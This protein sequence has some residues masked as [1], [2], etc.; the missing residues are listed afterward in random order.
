MPFV[1]IIFSLILN[2]IILFC[3]ILLQIY[4]FS[5]EIVLNFIKKL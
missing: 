1:V 3:I 2:N 5:A 4:D